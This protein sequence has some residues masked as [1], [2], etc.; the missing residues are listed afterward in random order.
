[1]QSSNPVLTRAEGFNGQPVAGGVSYP[2]Y[3]ETAPAGYAPGGTGHAPTQGRMTIDSVVQ[4]TALTLGLVVV[5]AA[6][7]WMFIGDI[8][9][10]SAMGKAWSLAIG[11][12]IGGLVLA[13]FVSFKKVIS[14]ALV[15]VYA[16]VEGAFVGAFSKIIATWV[17]D[18]SIVVQAVLG[19]FAAFAATLFVY[20]FFNIKVTDRFRRI[21]S[22]ALM[23]FVGLL[24]LNF[25]LS[26]FNADFG[27]RNFGAMGLIVG[28]VALVFAT[29]SL[30]MDFD[31]I[32]RGIAAGVD[33]RESWRAAFGLTV[34]LVWVYIE[35]L[36]ILAILR[37]D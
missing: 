34:T 6:L 29:I 8:D 5:G 27:L 31:M 36:R 16:L 33:E 2:A 11:G 15:V 3:D 32:E 35:L 21:F 20:K 13:M 22:I 30:I 26:F 17:G 14:P 19:T 24:L 10:E 23:G 37:G 28:V 1:M 7:A 25:I 12:A 18:F 4:K 9:S